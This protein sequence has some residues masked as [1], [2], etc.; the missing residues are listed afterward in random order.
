M[1]SLE[2]ALEHIAWAGYDGAELAYIASMV[3]HV[4]PGQGSAAAGHIRETAAGLGLDLYAIEVTPNT[5]ARVEAACQIAAG[6]EIPIVAIGSGGKTGDEDSFRQAVALGRDL[7][8][9]AGRHGVTLALKPHVGAAVYNTETALRALR[10][11]GSPHLG[12][13]FDP[14]HLARAGEDVAEAARRLTAAGAVVHSHFRDCLTTEIGGPPGPPVEQVPG[15][16][17]VDIPAVLRALAEGGYT[18]VLDLEV[19]GAKGYALS[20]AMGIAAEARGY[21]NRVLQEIDGA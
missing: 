9:I 3:E 15:R 12:L 13:N 10:E 20:R 1:A 6:L 21:L 2:E 11:I 19:I 16:G 18:G 7:A 14:S 8:A 17:R 5:P 4:H